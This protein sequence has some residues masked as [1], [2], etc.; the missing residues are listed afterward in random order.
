MV[1]KRHGHETSNIQHGTPNIQCWERQNSERFIS[2][3]HAYFAYLRLAVGG[4]AEGREWRMER[5][6]GMKHRTF[7]IERPTS[8]AGKGGR[9]LKLGYARIR[10]LICGE[11]EERTKGTTGTRNAEI[12]FTTCTG[13]RAQRVTQKGAKVVWKRGWPPP[14]TALYRLIP[15]YTAFLWGGANGGSS[16]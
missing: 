15:P 16:S 3:I 2:L 13:R 7:N 14:C 12:I 4:V 10:P 1:K 9:P 5:G 6:A 8:N 11:L